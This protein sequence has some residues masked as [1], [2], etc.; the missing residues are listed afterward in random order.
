M[1][2]LK[3]E[4]VKE[5]IM[6]LQGR[7]WRSSEGEQRVATHL[8]APL[9]KVDLTSAQAGLI[10][11][12]LSRGL[13][14]NVQKAQPEGTSHAVEFPGIKAGGFVV[15]LASLSQMSGSHDM[16]AVLGATPRLLGSK[17]HFIE[18]CGD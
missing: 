1:L 9:A 4:G 5:T 11:R 12:N 7:R 17:D 18:A 15:M 6:Q 3:F 16:R 2:R 14:K 8:E 10:I 13:H